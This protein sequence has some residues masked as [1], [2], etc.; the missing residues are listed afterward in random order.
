MIWRKSFIIMV[1]CIHKQ[2]WSRYDQVS[3]YNM[4][5]SEKGEVYHMIS[6]DCIPLTPGW[7]WVHAPCWICQVDKNIN[8]VP[9][10]QHILVAHCVFH[11]PWHVNHAIHFLFSYSPQIIGVSPA[12]I[13]KHFFC[14]GNIESH[15]NST[16]YLVD[17]F[18]YCGLVHNPH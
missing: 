14:T 4:L 17:G 6:Y 13:I 3:C 5:H 15:Q 16:T 1:N 8:H 2:L 7:I 12:S 11:V 18:P 9:L 10:A